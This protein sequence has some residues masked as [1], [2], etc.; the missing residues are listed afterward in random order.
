MS[1]GD[2]A[3]R[4]GE[5]T[6]ALLACLIARLGIEIGI[7]T[8]YNEGLEAISPA[9]MPFSPAKFRREFSA[10]EQERKGRKLDSLSVD[11]LFSLIF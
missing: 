4:R 10:E 5:G 8:I 2:K 11:A 9:Q 3:I 1:P 7:E 6:R